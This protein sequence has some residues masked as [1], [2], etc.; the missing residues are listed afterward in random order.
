M[1]NAEEHVGKFHLRMKG[2]P[3]YPSTLAAE[4]TIDSWP[5]TACTAYSRYLLEIGQSE[6]WVGLQVA[7]APCLLGYGAIAQ[8]L[9][10]HHL[11]KRDGN[12]YWTWIENYVAEDYVQAVQLGSGKFKDMLSWY[13]EASRSVQ[14]P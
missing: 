1:E 3:L 11:T 13:P 6:D 5:T 14:L 9:H 10:G 4:L 8:Q 7:L 2:N 12:P